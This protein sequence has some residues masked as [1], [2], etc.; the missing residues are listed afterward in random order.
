MELFST[1]M[2]MPSKASIAAQVEA[3][4]HSR[5]EMEAAV[6]ALQGLSAREDMIRRFLDERREPATRVKKR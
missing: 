2:K 3:V 1:L 5:M 4:R 6:T